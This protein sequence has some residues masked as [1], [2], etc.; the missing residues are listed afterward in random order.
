V[1]GR[2]SN[3]SEAIVL[4]IAERTDVNPVDLPPLYERVDPEALDS[5]VQGP[6]SFYVT[7]EYTGYEV[8]VSET[9]CIAIHERGND[10]S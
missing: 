2:D 10:R 3:P 9:G 7:F 4:E 5:L 6:G 8:T 1:S